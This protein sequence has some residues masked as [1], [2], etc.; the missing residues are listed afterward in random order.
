[1][2]EE[3]YILTLAVSKDQKKEI[4]GFLTERNWDG[5]ITGIYIIYV[6]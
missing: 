1:M 3:R 6:F 4:E 2:E 5:V